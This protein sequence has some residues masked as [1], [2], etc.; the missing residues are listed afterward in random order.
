[1]YAIDG[2]AKDGGYVKGGGVYKN[3]ESVVLTAIADECYTFV[4]WSDGETTP[5]RTIEVTG[6]ATYEAEFKL[7]TTTILV[8]AGSTNGTVRIEKVE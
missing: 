7:K 1:M 3:G 2:I 6:D 5:E 8:S 4:K